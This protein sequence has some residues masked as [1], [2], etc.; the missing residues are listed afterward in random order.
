MKVHLKNKKIHDFPTATWHKKEGNA[1]HLMRTER[2]PNGER[3]PVTVGVVDGSDVDHIEDETSSPDD[4][5]AD[6][7]DGPAK[8]VV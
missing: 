4:T 7:A 1:I 5:V 6:A 2:K 8:P 3:V